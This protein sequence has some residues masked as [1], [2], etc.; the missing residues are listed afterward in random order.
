MVIQRSKVI[1]MLKGMAKSGEIPAD[2]QLIVTQRLLDSGY[3]LKPDVEELE[4]ELQRASEPHV[5]PQGKK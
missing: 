3:L 5:S 2:V 1:D 4:Y